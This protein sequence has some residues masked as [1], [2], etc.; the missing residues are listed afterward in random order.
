MYLWNYQQEIPSCRTLNGSAPVKGRTKTFEEAQQDLQ[1]AEKRIAKKKKTKVKVISIYRNMTV[2]QIATQTSRTVDNILDA[3][4]YANSRQAFRGGKT[5]I[6]D[7]K[8]IQKT[9]TFLGYRSRI[10]ANPEMVVA[11]KEENSRDIEPQP[12]PDPSV[13]VRRPPVVTIM[14]HV[15]HGKTTLLDALRNTNVVAQEFGGITQHIGAFS[16]KMSSGNTISFLDTPGHAAFSHMRARGA[17]LT[18]IIILVV[19]A[20]DGLMPQTVESIQ[21]AK[22]ADVPLIVAINKMDK[23]TADVEGTEQMLLQ[24][25]VIPEKFGGDVQCVPIS[26]LKGTNLQQLQ[27]A[28]ITLAE[29]MDLKGDPVGNVEGRVIES[30]LVTGKGKV[31]TVIIE[32]GTLKKGNLL[33][34]GTSYAKVYFLSV[35]NSLRLVAKREVSTLKC[36]VSCL[37]GRG[38]Y[39]DKGSQ[40]KEATL[41]SPVEVTGWKEFPSAGDQVLQAQSEKQIKEA[42]DWRN[43]LKMEEKMDTDQEAINEKREK[44]DAE[45]K[46]QLQLRQSLGRREYNF[47]LKTIKPNRAKEEEVHH[48]GPS[49]SIV[50]KGDVDGS[51]DAILNTLDTYKSQICRLSIIHHGVGEVAMSDIDNA[52]LF[53]GEIF[54]FNVPVSETVRE[55]AKLNNVVIHE[56]NVIYKLFDNLVDSLSKR[57]PLRE[58]QEIMG[59]A[60]VMDSFNVSFKKKPMRIAGCRVTSGVLQ[61]K[62]KFRIIREEEEIYNGPIVS[63]KHHKS[64][65]E[66]IK[67][68][69]ECGLSISDNEIKFERGDVIICYRNYTAEQTLDWTPGF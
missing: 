24:Y 37:T 66:T 60:T 55:H 65:V 20:D 36:D 52:K 44:H 10:I 30:R 15:D 57:L 63:L 31:A 6:T 11:K 23:H 42:I 26:A 64:E 38:I 56:D 5:E 17:S 27:E 3:L 21:H 43:S 14:G 19:A 46:K 2:S 13:L 28:V 50:L 18:D 16:V 25:D 22:S 61:R 45:Y 62:H 8:V 51:I 69:T 48:E 33:I 7:V 40:L 49:L 29:L 59:E 12:P 9:L 34:A 35:I 67:Q 68:D 54:A 58:E 47:V 1:K 41:S 39:S 32:R 4:E 53:D